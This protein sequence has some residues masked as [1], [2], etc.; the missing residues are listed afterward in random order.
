MS[1]LKQ[2][3]LGILATALIMAISLGFISLFDFPE[4]FR[5]DRHVPDLHHSHGNCHGSDMG[6]EAAWFRRRALAAGARHFVQPDRAR[7]RR[8]VV[9]V[10][11]WT[12]S[13]AA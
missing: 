13:E 1:G 5:M 12:A 3:V 2:P 4:V 9:A 7:C 10:S 11:H 8:V 6:D